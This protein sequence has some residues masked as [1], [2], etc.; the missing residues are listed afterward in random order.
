M[1]SLLEKE[2]AHIMESET[3]QLFIWIAPRLKIKTLTV[4]SFSIRA[5]REGMSAVCSVPS[6]VVQ[7]AKAGMKTWWTALTTRS[8]GSPR[9]SSISSKPWSKDTNNSCSCLNVNFKKWSHSNMFIY[10]HTVPGS[11]CQGHLCNPWWYPDSW[12]QPPWPCLPYPQ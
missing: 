10:K 2:T 11:T 8:D 12:P 9:D 6:S 4:S 7:A 5:N 3:V 1:F